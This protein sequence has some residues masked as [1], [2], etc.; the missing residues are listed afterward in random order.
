MWGKNTSILLSACSPCYSAGRRPDTW[1][2]LA[3]ARVM[4]WVHLHKQTCLMRTA[5]KVHGHTH[6]HVCLREKGWT[7]TS[8]EYLPQESSSSI[9]DGPGKDGQAAGRVFRPAKPNLNSWLWWIEMIRSPDL[10]QTTS[11]ICTASSLKLPHAKSSNLDIWYTFYQLKVH[12]CW[13]SSAAPVQ[14]WRYQQS[15]AT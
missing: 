11:I 5:L 2:H 10:W 9:S 1:H 6:C 8:K 12:V 3:S 4:C 15:I 14:D 13:G 7:N